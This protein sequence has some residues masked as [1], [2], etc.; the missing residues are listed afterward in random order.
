MG[1][2]PYVCMA[3]DRA[4]S[5]YKLA[6]TARISPRPANLFAFLEIG[7]KSDTAALGGWRVNE[8]TKRPENAGDRF[9]VGLERAFEIIELPRKCSIGGEELAQPNEGPNDIEAHL[10][11]ATAV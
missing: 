7:R 8:S 9:V 6:F 5:N 11:G 2:T 10:D 1:F 3:S 4:P